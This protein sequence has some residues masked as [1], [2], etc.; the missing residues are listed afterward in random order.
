MGA[1]VL[2]L[3]VLIEGVQLEREL[4]LL[5]WP[6]SLILPFAAGCRQQQCTPANRT[7]IETESKEAAMGNVGKIPTAAAPPPSGEA[8]IKEIP[9]ANAEAG[10]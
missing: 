8:E 3:F 7:R 2:L 6:C 1:G 5:A 9:L 4:L 10:D